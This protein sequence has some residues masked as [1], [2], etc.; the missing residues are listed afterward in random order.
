[1]ALMK[2]ARVRESK[3]TSGSIENCKR[4]EIAKM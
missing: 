2:V 1:M 4:K 3:V